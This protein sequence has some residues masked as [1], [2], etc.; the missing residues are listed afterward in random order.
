VKLQVQYVAYSKFNGG[1]RNY[2][3]SGRDASDNNTLYLLG[4]FNF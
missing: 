2:D 1:A 3:G 4:W